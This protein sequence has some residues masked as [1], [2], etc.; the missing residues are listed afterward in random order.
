MIGYILEAK[1][2]GD[3]TLRL[4]VDS[5]VRIDELKVS[6][7][8]LEK[9]LTTA[10]EELRE[11]K[12]GNKMSIQDSRSCSLSSLYRTRSILWKFCLETHPTIG[13]MSMA[14][15]TEVAMLHASLQSTAAW[16]QK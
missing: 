16:K 8:V 9:A 10:N 14:S 1:A 3:N 5:G 6:A 2:I 15:R 12:G 13:R 11:L 7:S 4:Q